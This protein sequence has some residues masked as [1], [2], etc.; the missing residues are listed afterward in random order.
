MSQEM[1]HHLQT[2][3]SHNAQIGDILKYRLRASDHPTDPEKIWRGT[4]VY[5]LTD[6]YNSRVYVVESLNF[7]EDGLEV[8]YAGQVV[9]YEPVN[10]QS[11]DQE[12]GPLPLPP[13]V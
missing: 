9:G 10:R 13:P 5:I 12:P 3:P 6:R 2:K 8:V 7:P 11:S 1:H 4:I